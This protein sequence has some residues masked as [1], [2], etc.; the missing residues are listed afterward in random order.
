MPTWSWRDGLALLA[1]ACLVAA[2]GC[3]SSA[4]KEPPPPDDEAASL[5]AE[6]DATA[7]AGPERATLDDDDHRDEH[8]TDPSHD[9]GHDHDHDHAKG[10]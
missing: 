7:D 9:H 4:P 3:A 2:P 10:K 8:C 5:R 1:V 6:A